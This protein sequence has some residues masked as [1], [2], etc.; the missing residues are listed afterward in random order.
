MRGGVSETGP[1]DDVIARAR[2]GDPDAWRELY[3]AHAGRLVL[4]LGSLR[5][6][7]ASSGPEDIAADA[8]LTAARRIA[9]FSGDR[10]AFAGWLFGIARNMSVNSSRRAARRRTDPSAF[11]SEDTWILGVEED[12]TVQVSDDDAVRRL[13][14]RLPR[15]EA[16][17]VACL[18]VV[19]LDT[20]LTAATLGIST[21]A[22]RVAHHRAIA[23]LRKLMT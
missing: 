12:P 17:V 9:D 19:G 22:V 4:W 8:W 13:L 10:D 18:D 20:A 11:D 2:A 1:V 5:H 23:R 3:E 14:S 15:R 16:E 21:T 6:A 7:D